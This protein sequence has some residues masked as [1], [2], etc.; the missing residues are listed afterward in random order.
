MSETKKG[1]PDSSVD[2][3]HGAIGDPA[4]YTPTYYH[5]DSMPKHSPSYK[6]YHDKSE[7]AKSGV[8]SQP[9]GRTSLPSASA[10][11]DAK[12]EEGTTV[13]C[14]GK[15]TGLNRYPINEHEEKERHHGPNN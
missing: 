5:K 2:F 15:Q 11:T 3:Q 9:E 1:T 8:T 7:A 10:V 12:V 14:A 4:D 13:K 6:V